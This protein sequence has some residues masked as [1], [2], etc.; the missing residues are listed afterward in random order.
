MLGIPG[1]GKLVGVSVAMGGGALGMIW[2]SKFVDQDVAETMVELQE[3]GVRKAAREYPDDASIV[4]TIKRRLFPRRPA[5]ILAENLE[6]AGMPRPKGHEAH[7]MVAAGD[8]RAS[9][10]RLLLEEAGIDINSAANGIWLPRTS[11]DTAVEAAI[12]H[13]N[14]HTDSYYEEITRRLAAVAPEQRKDVL[15]RAAIQMQ[16]GTFPHPPKSSR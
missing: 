5:E 16:L 2:R 7:H 10:A 15:T 12:R 14:I 9:E 1:G 4:D 3:R 13:P 8:E 6:L 11:I